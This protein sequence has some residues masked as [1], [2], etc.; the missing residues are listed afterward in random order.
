MLGAQRGNDIELTYPTPSGRIETLS[1]SRAS[2]N[3][4][5]NLLAEWQQQLKAQYLG[6]PCLL[7]VKGHLATVA[8]S[9]IK[10][11]EWC[12]SLAQNVNYAMQ[13]VRT[14]TASTALVC[15][16]QL[17]DAIARVQD[18]GG[19]DYGRDICRQL[20]NM[21]Q[22]SPGADWKVVQNNADRIQ[23]LSAALAKAIADVQKQTKAIEPALTQTRSHAN[24]QKDALNT[25]R[26]HLNEMKSHGAVRPMTCYQANQVV[27]YDYEQ[28]LRYDLEQ[29]LGYERSQLDSAMSEA[30]QLL[31]NGDKSIVAARQAS[32]AL[33]DAI[34]NNSSPSPPLTVRPGDEEASISSYTQAAQAARDT[35]ASIN[36]GAKQTFAGNRSRHVSEWRG[37]Q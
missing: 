4:F 29:N 31:S 32:Q 6:G 22:L 33:A 10:A 27:R 35:L 8:F 1:F 20:S 28:S 7:S 36:S 24:E 37:G 21:S 15:T 12:D 25:M 13:P 34:R 5:N 19:Q 17:T 2:Q 14:E 16:V 30:T 23:S 18:A 26:S 3:Q 9:G 11:H